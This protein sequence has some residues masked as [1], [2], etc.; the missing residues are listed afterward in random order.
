MDIRAGT[1]ADTAALFDFYRAQLI[2]D[3]VPFWLRNSLDQQYG[4]YLTFLRRDGTPYGY[5]KYVWP[6]AREAYLFSKLYNDLDKRDEWLHAS[7]LGV[8]FL[9]KFAFIDDVRTHFKLARN[10]VPLSDRPHEI[11]AESFVVIALAEYARAAQREEF[12]DS[13]LRLFWGIVS[14]LENGEL[15]RKSLVVQPVYREHAPTMILI[16]TAQGLRDIQNNARLNELI[17][18]WVTDELTIYSPDNHQAMFE[19]VASNG[20]VDL[21]EPEGRSITPG[22]CMESSW[23]C[24]TEGARLGRQ[25]TIAKAATIIEWTIRHGWDEEF[26]GLFNYVDFRR[27]P[28][29]H[30][31]ENWG[32]DQDWDAKL[33]WVHSEALYA[34]LLAFD[35][36]GKELF[37][38]WYRKL[39]EWAF[40]HFPDPQ[41][42]EWYGYLRRDGTISQTLK[43]G[44]KGFFHV[45]RA[46][47]NCLLLLDKRQK[48]L[49]GAR[50]EETCHSSL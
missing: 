16:N 36:T 1:V 45:P 47:L 31:D 11:F 27:D 42:G 50:G 30:H 49:K 7:R 21:T 8:E 14:R 4:G 17:E 28:P 37:F 38:E 48:R 24:M 23:F 13:A 20:L 5:N 10:G 32:E 34:L 26:G 43:G 29:G 41:F 9:R 33:D 2:D 15:E 3:C 46:L 22:H 39:H 19:R 6:Q 12:L 44:M 18:K 25:D 40:S 35:L